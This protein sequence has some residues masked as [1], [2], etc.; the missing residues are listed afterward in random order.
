MDF[1]D[2]IAVIESSMEVGSNQNPDNELLGL[3]QKL[4]NR[5]LNVNDA[6]QMMLDIISEK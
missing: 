1:K 6:D 3:F 2:K 4:A 5:E